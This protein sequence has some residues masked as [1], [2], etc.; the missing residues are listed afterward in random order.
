MLRIRKSALGRRRL[1]EALRR[2]D[3]R[4]L[5]ELYREHAGTVLGYLRATLRD[6]G[7]A[8]DVHQ[9]VFLEVWQRAPDY[10]P[11]RGGLVTWILTIARSRAI[12]ELRRRVPEPRDPSESLEVA[13]A[14][15]GEE[16]ADRL[17]EEWQVAHLLGRL[18]REES[19]LLRLRFHYGLSQSEIAERMGL[20]L[21]TVKM[22]MVQ[23]LQRLRD[24]IEAEEPA[25]R[26]H[27]GH[28]PA[29]LAAA[30][31]ARA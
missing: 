14:P 1:A 11:E 7:M 29:P 8:E 12:D 23:A 13:N 17:V 5:D 21:G 19:I 24:L 6:R 27:T 20:P 25:K 10:D 2:R 15:A 18:R 31:R 30:E 28:D 26:A 22:R 9:Q 16:F 3:P 4:A